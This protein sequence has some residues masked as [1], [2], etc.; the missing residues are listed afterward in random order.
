MQ[1][2]VNDWNIPFSSFPWYPPLYSENLE[3][4]YY[5]LKTVQSLLQNGHTELGHVLSSSHSDTPLH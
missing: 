3:Q 4:G 5:R 1:K 2:T